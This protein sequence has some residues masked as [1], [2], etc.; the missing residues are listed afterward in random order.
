M[1]ERPGDHFQRRA[2]GQKLN[3]KRLA[4]AVRVSGL[5]AGLVENLLELSREVF[6]NRDRFAVA[7]PEN[8][9]GISVGNLQERFPHFRRD[10][11]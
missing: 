7:A 11:T 9:L 6:G 5:N 8:V 1:T 2:V 10:N 3:A 4:E